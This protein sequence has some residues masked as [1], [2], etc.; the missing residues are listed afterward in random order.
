VQKPFLLPYQV[1][2]FIGQ[3]NHVPVPRAMPSFWVMSTVQ[4]YIRRDCCFG[5]ICIE[6][7]E[8]SHHCE[9]PGSSK[10]T[11]LVWNLSVQ[12][13]E[14]RNWQFVVGERYA[15]ITENVDKRG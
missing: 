10:S 5:F 11:F 1:F 7:L 2:L 14:N 9:W 8:A 13:R 12:G 15:V 6:Y 4:S 3:R